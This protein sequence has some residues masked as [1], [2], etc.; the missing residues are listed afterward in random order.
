MG[1]SRPRAYI[2]FQRRAAA[3]VED[4]TH[5]KDD[6]DP[7]KNSGL[8]TYVCLAALTMAHVA[9]LAWRPRADKGYV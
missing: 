3:R 9:P 1:D 2:P 4:R 8:T 7:A 5:V 6:P